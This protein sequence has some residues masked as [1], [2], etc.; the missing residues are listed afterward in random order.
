MFIAEACQ[1]AGG[2]HCMPEGFVNKACD[3]VR[4]AGG[5][6]V[7]DEVQIGFARCGT[8]FWGFEKLGATPDIVVMG[9]TIGNGMPLACLATTKEIAGRMDKRTL[10][11]Y[12]ANPMAMAVGRE[13]LKVIDE[14]GLQ[15]NC[16]LRGEQMLKGLREL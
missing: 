5:I 12:A 8:D 1:G 3:I 7:A 16:R 14:E 11:T 6:Y 13:V 9:K 10:S 2:V 15:E 4:K